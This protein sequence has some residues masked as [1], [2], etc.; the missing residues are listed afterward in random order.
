MKTAIKP[1]FEILWISIQHYPTITYHNYNC[2]FDILSNPKT[3]LPDL[4]CEPPWQ[5]RQ[6]LRNCSKCQTL[7][8]CLWRW[9]A[10]GIWWPSLG[11]WSQFTDVHSNP[12]GSLGCLWQLTPGAVVQLSTL[13]Y[14]WSFTSANECL[15]QPRP[16]LYKHVDQM[17]RALQH[18]AATILKEEAC[19]LLML[20]QTWNIE[21]NWTRRP[22]TSSLPAAK[23]HM[24]SASLGVRCL[25]PDCDFGGCFGTDNMAVPWFCIRQCFGAMFL[26]FEYSTCP[27]LSSF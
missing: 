7:C 27:P 6:G 17:T 15:Q 20:M 21:I 25:G 23:A 26:Y 10:G 18:I 14:V 3:S 8:R 5:R 12:W 24:R 4:A 13:H 1:D 2:T 16:G 22:I 9:Q 11:H 19:W